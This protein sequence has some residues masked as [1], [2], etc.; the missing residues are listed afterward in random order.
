[1]LFFELL[2]VAIG[3]RQE[4][5][6]IPTAEG[7]RELFVLAQRQA[8]VGIAFRGVELLPEAQRPPKPLLM[9]WYMAAER[10]KA[11][12]AD[13]DR[14]ALAVA[15]KF[16]EEGFPGVVLK[17]QGI[18][19]LYRVGQIENSRFKIEDCHPEGYAQENENDNEN[20]GVGEF[21][22]KE[23]RTPG[24][25][26]IWLHGERKD[27]LRYVHRHVPDCK[28]VYHHVDFPV[29]EGLD[30]EVHFTPSWMNSPFTNRR[31]QQWF[32]ESAD[33]LNYNEDRSYPLRSTNVPLVPILPPPALRARPP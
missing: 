32:R 7:W 23:Y 33:F 4:L 15:N 31:L 10:I 2:Q 14:K 29:I 9:Q 3:N 17:G 20:Q 8:L 11:M 24:D 28:P 19:Q 30:I 16:L 25:I 27:I 12:N 26:D 18:A 5:T 22:I 21:S 1:M 13:L 6:H